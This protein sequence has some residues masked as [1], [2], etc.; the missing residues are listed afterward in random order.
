VGISGLNRIKFKF[1]QPSLLE[2]IDPRH[3]AL[4]LIFQLRQVILLC[5]WKRLLQ[6]NEPGQVLNSIFLTAALLLQ[7]GYQV[8]IQGLF[9]KLLGQLLQLNLQ[10]SLISSGVTLAHIPLCCLGR[11]WLLGVLLCNQDILHRSGTQCELF[12]SAQINAKGIEGGGGWLTLGSDLA[13]L[14]RYISAYLA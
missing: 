10:E 13:S 11:P 12:F 9:L 14:W 6:F 2:V 3:H 7:V 5:L 4:N 1:R 8:S